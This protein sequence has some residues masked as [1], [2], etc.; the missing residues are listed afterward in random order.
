MRLI[1]EGRVVIM[2][3]FI[4]QQVMDRITIKGMQDRNIW[5]TRDYITYTRQI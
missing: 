3:K 2:K 1:K 5:C 4:R